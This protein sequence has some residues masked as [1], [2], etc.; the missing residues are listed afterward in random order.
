VEGGESAVTTAYVY[1]NPTREPESAVVAYATTR[2]GSVRLGVVGVDGRL[3]AERDLVYDPALPPPGTEVGLSTVPLGDV[4]QGR[5][6]AAGLY[7]LRVELFHGEGGSAD[8]AIAK[9]AVLR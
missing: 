1:P 8:V 3:I 5:Q 2:D 6:I 9:F 7:L 4:L